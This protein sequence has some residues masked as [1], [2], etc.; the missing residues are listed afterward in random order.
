MGFFPCALYET[1][2]PKLQVRLL[3]HEGV[4]LGYTVQGPYQ[5]T[6][7]YFIEST[8]T[9]IAQ[10]VD[11]EYDHYYYTHFFDDECNELDLV[12]VS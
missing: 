9:T 8:P 2:M 5:L 7:E 4:R 11:D 12:V 10:L 6:H 1:L 3:H